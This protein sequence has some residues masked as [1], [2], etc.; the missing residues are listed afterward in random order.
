MDKNPKK[1]LLTEYT[2]AYSAGKSS[3][4]LLGTA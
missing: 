1:K 4:Q 2:N 3:N